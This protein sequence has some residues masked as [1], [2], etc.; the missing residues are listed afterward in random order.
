MQD[1]R[2]IE[3]LKELLDL[4]KDMVVF[5]LS[6]LE[7]KSF[8]LCV[9]FIHCGLRLRVE[10]FVCL[11]PSA[12]NVVNGTIGKQMVDMLVESSGNVEMILKFFD[13]FL[14]LKDLTS[15][16]TFSEYDPD[17]NGCISK[18]DFQKAM[19]GCKRFSHEETHFLLSCMETSNGETVDYVAFVDRFH[20]PAK[21]IG[22][23]IAVLLTNLSEHMPNDLRLQTFLEPA[24]CVLTYFQPYLGRIEILGGGKRIE[25][26]YFEISESSRTQWEKPQVKES[27]RQFIFDVVNE[28][29]DKEKMEM[30]VNFCE[31]TIFEMQLAAQ[32]SGTDGGGV[33]SDRGGGER[34]AIE[35][36]ELHTEEAPF[37]YRWWFSLASVLSVKRLRAVMK[38]SLKDLLTAVMLL[39]KMILVA[40]LRCVSALVQGIACVLYVAFIDCGLV[41]GAKR[42]TVLELL[43]GILEPTLDEVT[44]SPSG[45]AEL[46]RFSSS[47]SLQRELSVGQVAAAASPGEIDLLSEI[48]GLRVTREGGRYRLASPD[49]G[50]T[51]GDTSSTASAADISEK[52]YKLVWFLFLKQ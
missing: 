42:T 18:K 43:S 3:I 35:E 31:D 26:V 30:F 9:T 11:S 19:E 29:G 32:L 1:L 21:D 23:S 48:F 17:S 52:H 10:Q 45:I 34:S 39:L 8:R 16:D 12:G 27:K 41:E 25:R 2:Q 6:M 33:H 46:R 28:G 5:L 15:S 22:F 50:S 7:G 24:E 44:G 49:N 38:M 37:I 51:W 40:Q 36:R 13:M 20:E 47:L 4:Q 14:K